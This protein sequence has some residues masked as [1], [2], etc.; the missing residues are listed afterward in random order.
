LVV[1]EHDGRGE[2]DGLFFIKHLIIVRNSRLAT[3]KKPQSLHDSHLAQLSSMS[4]RRL[5]IGLVLP[6]Y[7]TVV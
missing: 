5:P 3:T 4:F 2:P 1:E 6:R 7:L